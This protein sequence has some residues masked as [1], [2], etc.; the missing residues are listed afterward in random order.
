L[1]SPGIPYNVV[2]NMFPAI[3]GNPVGTG[4]R[5]SVVCNALGV[6]QGVATF[7]AVEAPSRA[8]PATSPQ[9]LLAL[10]LLIAGAAMWHFRGR[11]S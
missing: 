7:S 10:A 9:A 3:N 8:I 1:G 2:S 6:G 5:I 4:I 11:R